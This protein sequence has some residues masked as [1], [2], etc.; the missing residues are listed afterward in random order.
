MAR[1]GE[2][3]AEEQSFY[4]ASRKQLEQEEQFQEAANAKHVRVELARL[5]QDHAQLER[6]R[7]QLEADIAQ[8]EARL[9][10]PTRQFLTVG[11]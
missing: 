2:L 3:S 7:R 5:E 11:D 10:E 8:L 6:Q 4:E 1:G 9:S